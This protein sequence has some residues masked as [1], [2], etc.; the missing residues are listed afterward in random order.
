[1]YFLFHC[2]KQHPQ[3]KFEQLRR[4]RGI[5]ACDLVRQESGAEPTTHTTSEQSHSNVGEQVQRRVWEGE[6][7]HLLL[8]IS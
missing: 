8:V 5:A 2:S 3:P 4:G 7:A 1:M 6:E